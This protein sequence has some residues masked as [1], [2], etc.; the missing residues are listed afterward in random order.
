M[1]VV[2]KLYTKLRV[3]LKNS[4]LAN[5]CR[6][7]NKKQI[8]FSV[9]LY[10]TNVLCLRCQCW[11]DRLWAAVGAPIE[12]TKNNVADVFLVLLM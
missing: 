5:I 8:F 7:A 9:Q 11:T 4:T 3:C 12:S 10:Y 6:L 1:Q 2:Q